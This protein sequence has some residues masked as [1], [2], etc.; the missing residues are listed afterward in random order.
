MNQKTGDIAQ[1]MQIISHLRHQ[2]SM[3][4]SLHNITPDDDNTYTPENNRGYL[5][6]QDDTVLA[7]FNPDTIPS[8]TALADALKAVMPATAPHEFWVF[9][10]EHVVEYGT[11]QN[12]PDLGVDPDM[13]LAAEMV[14]DAIRAMTM[15]ILM[16]GFLANKPHLSAPFLPMNNLVQQDMIIIKNSRGPEKHYPTTAQSMSSARVY[17]MDTRLHPL[18]VF[19]PHT[20]RAS[21]LCDTIQSF[22]WRD[23]VSRFALLHDGVITQGDVSDIATYCDHLLLP[24]SGSPSRDHYWAWVSFAIFRFSA[25]NL[26]LPHMGFDY[27]EA[28]QVAEHLGLFVTASSNFQAWL[29]IAQI[30][31]L[32]LE[33][34]LPQQTHSLV[35]A[36]PLRGY[37]LDEAQI[38][39][40]AFN[41]IAPN[42]IPAM[43]AAIEQIPALT[44]GMSPPGSCV[45]LTG[46]KVLSI[47][48][49][50]AIKANVQETFSEKTLRYIY[51]W[52]IHQDMRRVIQSAGERIVTIGF[53]HI[54]TANTF[55]PN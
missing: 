37:I 51:L 45:I 14:M 8:V 40:L 28:S 55:S 44:H 32:I 31:L 23:D 3:G 2:M 22:G 33:G 13:G 11:L 39:I 36:L 42:S 17:L 25:D 27:Y 53:G 34:Q 10:Q 26:A 15:P 24:G 38:P 16:V 7:V 43:L 21:T 48:D 6:S 47:T 50:A 46:A 20:I 19:N 29:P 12:T 1:D 52:E 18:M 5:L 4:R 49:V 54:P 41:P 9:N 35:E 30:D